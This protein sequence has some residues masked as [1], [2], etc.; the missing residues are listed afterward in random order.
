M[1]K[2]TGDKKDREAE[3]IIKNWN[4]LPGWLKKMILKEIW[5]NKNV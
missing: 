3:Y 4:F 5:K 2:K 1:S